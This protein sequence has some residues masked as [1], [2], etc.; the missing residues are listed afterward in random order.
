MIAVGPSFVVMPD[1]VLADFRPFEVILRGIDVILVLGGFDC[2]AEPVQ[3]FLPGVPR[4]FEDFVRIEE[5]I[6]GGI[7]HIGGKIPED[8]TDII[9][10][11]SVAAGIQ[12][13]VMGAHIRNM[14]SLEPIQV[15]YGRGVVSSVQGTDRA[16]FHS[17]PDQDL[18]FLCQRGC[19]WQ[20][21]RKCQRG[22]T[23]SKKKE[24]FHGAVI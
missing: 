6:R 3:D 21:G 22:S 17:R 18:V 1:D 2:L 7:V 20:K 11:T 10:V 8:R 14:R 5:I 24:S 16:Y 15:V 19:S 23:S 12:H 4:P 9:N 13:G